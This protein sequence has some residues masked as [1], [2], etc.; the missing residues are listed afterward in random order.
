MPA[1]L[2]YTYVWLRVDFRT[3]FYKTC[4]SCINGHLLKQKHIILENYF[5]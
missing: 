2:K 3:F 4:Y 1:N 5:C